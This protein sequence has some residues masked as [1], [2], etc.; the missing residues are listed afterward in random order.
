[1]F[2]LNLGSS[3]DHRSHWIYLHSTMFLLNLNSK[4]AFEL[5]GHIFTFHYVSI[6]SW[7][8]AFMITTTIWFT[9]HYVSI[10]SS[11]VNSFSAI[12]C[13]LHSTM[14]L[15]NRYEQDSQ[16][17]KRSYLHSTMFLLNLMQCEEDEIMSQK[18]TFH[19]VSI[20]SP[21]SGILRI[22]SRHLHSTMFLL[23]LAT[24]IY[25]SRFICIYIPLCFY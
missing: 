3:Q 6:K 15:L 11:S 8:R 4:E 25:F 16:Y 12:L 10:K 20:K 18:F 24:S 13:N 22:I 7:T 23:N 2:L 9:F 19:Y 21:W 1:M 5:I 14:F 17:S